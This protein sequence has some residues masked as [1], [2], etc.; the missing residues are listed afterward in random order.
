MEED[1]C[2]LKCISQVEGR[3]SVCLMHGAFLAQIL[4]GRWT[5]GVYS[6]LCRLSQKT[7]QTAARCHPGRQQ[8]K[9]G[10]SLATREGRAS[11]KTHG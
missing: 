5:V 1:T 8:V 9:P 10:Y 7:R 6:R 11:V 2:V 4:D 3:C